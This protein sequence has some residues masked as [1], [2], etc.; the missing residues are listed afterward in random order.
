MEKV[1]MTWSG[2]K[3]SAL[4]LYKILKSKKYR[5]ISLLTTL[6]KGYDRISMHGVRRVLLEQQAK[7]LG[8]PVKEIFIPK[9]CTNKIYEKR[10]GDALA[11]FQKKGVTSVVFGDIFLETVRKYRDENLA[12]IGM[13][14]I[15]PLWG[16]NTKKLARNFI[17]IGFKSIVV[18]V[19]SRSFGSFSADIIKGFGSIGK[20]YDKEFLGELPSNWDPCGENGE[21][22]T[23][24]FD[25][26]IFKNPVCFTKGK[27][28]HRDSFYFCDLV[29]KK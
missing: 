14:G 27:I 10:M 18:C 6:T 19:D 12:K 1:I 9:E 4:A 11:D 28:V 24:V 3:D 2:G 22:H 5:V 29:P 20:R 26:P 16:S 23:F 13:R 21:F 15:Y 25:G 7:S 17:A 8:L